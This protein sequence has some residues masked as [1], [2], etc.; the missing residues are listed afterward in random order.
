M[1]DRVAI[2]GVGFTALQ[3]SMPHLS[4]KELTFEAAQ[5]AYLDAG[6]Q[7]REIDS[8]VT[9]AED[10]NEGISIFDEYTPDQLG[11]VQKP[12][13]TLTQD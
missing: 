12:M 7:P 13:H 3:P 10:L 11:A 8:F 5:K 4:F 2:I 1:N 6:V 9:C